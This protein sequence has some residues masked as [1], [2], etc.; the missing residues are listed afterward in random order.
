MNKVTNL[1]VA[2]E[3]RRQKQPH[4]EGGKGFA[5]IH[6]QFM[7][8]KLY[9]D[10]QAVHLW[11]HLILKA[12]HSPA[13]VDT[14]LGEMLV[15]RGQ[16]IT[17]RPKLVS[18]TFIPDNKIKSL[19]RSFETHGMIRIESKGRKFSLITV[20]KYDEFQPQNCPTDV[21]RLSN[22]NTH[23]ERPHEG[24]CPTDVQRLSINNNITNKSISNEIDMSSDDDQPAGKKSKPV[25]YQAVMNAY[26]EAVGERLPNAEKLNP[27]RRAAIKRLMSELKEPTVEAASNYFMAFVDSAGRFYFGDNDRGWKAHFD[28]V[29][30]PDTLT[31]TREGTL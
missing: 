4:L 2:R 30:R 26:N 3:V 31:K 17:G 9:K 13:V 29:L 14:E 16:M 27:K 6:R 10:S 5:L 25:P 8:S 22:V 21:Q 12:N 11:L 24:V 19:L 23:S 28:Y 20:L 15:S 18:E 7:D 1:A